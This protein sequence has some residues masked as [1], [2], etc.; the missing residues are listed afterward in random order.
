MKSRHF[1]LT[2][3]FA[4]AVLGLSTAALAATVYYTADEALLHQVLDE[5]E[6]EYAVTLD[7]DGDPV[8]TFTHSGILITIVSY[9]EKESDRYASLLFYAGWAADTAVSL[10]A[11]N[12]WNR[13]SRFGRAYVDETGDPA[14]ELD[15]LLT[16]GVT[17]QTLKE[18]IEVFVA[19]VSDLGVAL[20]L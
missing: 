18:Y 13:R 2:A 14:I 12:D 5:M 9:D 15:L 16:G 19:T 8:W 7:D 4:L 6:I 1:R 11:I 17:A 3:V 10:F 20:Q